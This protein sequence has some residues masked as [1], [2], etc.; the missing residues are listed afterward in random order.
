MKL[1]KKQ[2]FF[3]KK[4]LN[5]INIAHGAVRSGKS[6]AVNYRWIQY[7]H[8]GPPG[9]LLMIGKT[10]RTL[11]RNIINPIIELL[12]KSAK[13]K[14]GAGEFYIGSRRCYVVGAN[15]ERAEQK[16][17]GLTAAGAYADEIS[18]YPKSFFD[19]LLTRL[20]VTDA[21]LFGTTNPDSPYH[22]LKTDYLDNPDL[23]LYQNHFEIDDNPF[24]SSEFIS[25]LKNSF[26]GIFYKRNIL[27][28]WVLA[29]GVVFDMFSDKRHVIDTSDFV[30]DHYTI[31]IDYGIA[32]P[33]VFLKTGHIADK[34]YVVSEYYNTER[35]TD[36]QMADD[37]VR[38]IGDD[39]VTGI[40][41][42]PSA[43]SFITECSQKGLPVYSADNAVLTGISFISNMFEQGKLF[44]DVH[45][46]NLKN[47]LM[48]YSWDKKAQ[49]QG[50]DKPLKQHDHAPDAL[51]YDLFTSYG[52]QIFVG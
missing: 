27:G 3:I 40:N 15:D 24:L 21:K 33:T 50:I 51:R 6:V 4:S 5:W 14:G 43:L 30:F 9:D 46:E 2:I 22:W 48:T 23:N 31:G 17:K 11:H 49:L 18:T 36:S 35:K 34:H 16:I 29:E 10:E 42:D 25:N 8:T 26:S 52:S 20:S 39:N 45:C 32:N 44:I 37:L 13:Y 41:I 7:C 1:S 12:G 38:F 47:E 28:L 19:M